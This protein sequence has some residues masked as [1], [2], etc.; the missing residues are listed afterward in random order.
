MLQQSNSPSRLWFLP[1][2]VGVAV[3]LLTDCGERGTQ[4]AAPLERQCLA[5]AIGT[6]RR[7][8]TVPSCSPGDLVCRAKCLAGDAGSCLGMAYTAEKSQD[9]E[10]TSLYRRSCTLGAANACTNYAA[11]VWAGEPSAEQLACAQR[12]F[13]KAC[14]AKEPYACGMVGR[15]MLEG[16]DPIPYEE[17]RRYLE[18]ACET[19]GGFPCRVLARHLESG[20]LG[21]YPPERIRAL[22]TRACSGGDTDACGNPKSAAETFK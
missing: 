17:G 18:A 20:K 2:V 4:D 5:D 11:H 21:T 12:T 14:A 3:L 8:G 16:T 10:A 19:L 15:L 1:I 7:I 13:E 6:L 22:L 9:A